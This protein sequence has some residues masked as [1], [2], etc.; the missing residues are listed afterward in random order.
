[1]KTFASLL[2]LVF[3]I[4]AF[5]QDIIIKNS[6]DTISCKIINVDDSEITYKVKKGNI[7]ET[8][9]LP[10][11]YI[12]SFIIASIESESIANLQI[13]EPEKFKGF[14]IALA[15]GHAWGIGKLLKTGDSQLDKLSEDIRNGVAFD[16]E[17]QY[18]FN[19][20]YGIAL[21]FNQVTKNAKGNNLYVPGIGNCRNFE[22]VQTM[23]FIGPAF[24]ARYETKKILLTSSIGLGPIFFTSKAKAVDEHEY[25]KRMVGRSINFGINWGVGLEYKLS[26][27]WALG[28]KLSETFGYTDSM[29]VD[30]QT[31]YSDEKFSLSSIMLSAYASF[32]TF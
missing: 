26:P 13:D 15:G 27:K 14:R 8:N 5:S 10:R 30:G 7:I 21:N 28:A 17:L 22:E 31:L 6:N 24:A 23:T 16:A 3:S 25:K 9:T 1:M 18:F 4:S 12:S 11:R 29:T 20:S 2:L 32:R 19:P